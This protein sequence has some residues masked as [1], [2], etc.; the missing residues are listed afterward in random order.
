[1]AGGLFFAYVAV[2]LR[3]HEH[4]L[5]HSFDLGIFVQVVQS[6]AAGHLPVSEVKGPDFP[7]LGDHFSPILA[8]LAPLYWLWPSVKLLL[9]A[10]AA[11]VAASVLPLA[12]WAR[13]T[14]GSA[15]AVVIGVCYGVSWGIAS[16][17]GYDFH[18]WAFAVP[19]LAFS[20]TALGSDRLRAAAFWALPLVLVKEDLGLTVVVIGPLIAWR[21][22]PGGRRLGIVTA[23]VGLAA[24]ALV[25]P[26]LSAFHP[27]GFD[28][29]YASHNPRTADSGSGDL[30]DFLHT[31]TVGL[32][33]A[34]EK[35]TT[36]ILVLAPTLFLAVRSP[37]LLVALPCAGGTRAAAVCT[38]TWRAPRQSPCCSC[39]TSRCGS[40][41]SRRA[42][43]PT[44]A[45]R[46]PA[47]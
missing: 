30:L 36:L 29:Y 12:F 44:P 37:L 39:R 9:V 15:A 13:R 25:V 20:L 42:G 28:G 10:Q 3:I 35:V 45:W 5:S 24:T 41:F 33:T 7:V 47:V 19:L 46:W 22:G 23:S 40:W 4:L 34:Q 18:E 43:R 16:G 38:A 11:L 1:M 21:G 31:V 6:Y 14:L 32:I 2:S 26:V 27:G 17:V 8:V